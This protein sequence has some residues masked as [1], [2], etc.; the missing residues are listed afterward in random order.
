MGGGVVANVVLSKTKGITADGSLSHLA[1]RWLYFLASMFQIPWWKWSFKPC[2]NYCVSLHLVILI[3][4]CLVTYLAAQFG[5]AFTGAVIAWLAYKQHFDETADKDLKLAV[6]STARL[7]AIG[8]IIS[9]QRS[10]AHL[11]CVWSIDHVKTCFFIRNFRCIACWII[12]IGNWIILRRS[13][14]L[15]HQ[16]CKRPGSKNC[17]FYFT[18]KRKT[19]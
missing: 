11:S 17:S 5:G 6:F 14:R 3:L 12:G 2:S 9:L 16:S 18:N 7:F 1:G 4:H 8:F 13:Y 15:C 19:R 10:S